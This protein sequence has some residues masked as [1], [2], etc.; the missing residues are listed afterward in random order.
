MQIKIYNLQTLKKM[1]WVFDD[2]WLA[3]SNRKYLYK[4]ELNLIGEIVTYLGEWENGDIRVEHKGVE[5]IL[6]NLEY[7]LYEFC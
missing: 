3:F 1:G 2:G 7:S 4:E 5:Y 6:P